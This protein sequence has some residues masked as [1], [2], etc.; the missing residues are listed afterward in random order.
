MMDDAARVVG[1]VAAVPAGGLL[2]VIQSMASTSQA[3]LDLEVETL[4]DSQHRQALLNRLRRAAADPGVTALIV[5]FSSPPG[6]WAACA[7]LRVALQRLRRAGKPVYAVLEQPG[8]AL[9]WMASVADRV[10]L[11]PTGEVLLVGIAAELTFFG[12]LLARIGVEPD[13]EAAGTYKSFG[14]PYT[15][16]FASPANQEAIGALIADL[17]DQ[18]VTGLAEARNLTVETVRALLDRAPLS[19]QDALDARLVDALAYNDEVETWIEE[20]HGKRTKK[21]DFLAWA[22]R[23]AA[24][25]ATERWGDVAE[26]IAVVHLDGAIVV[27]D[28]SPATLIRARRVVPLLAKLREDDDVKAVVLHVNSGGGGALASDLIWREVDLLQ[29]KKPVIA[30]FEDV[31]ASG[32]FYLAAPAAEILARPTT[33]TGSIGVFGGKLVVGE[34]MRKIGVHAHSIAGAPN[35]A[36]FS[37]ARHFTPDQRT[38]FKASLQRFYDGFVGRVAAGRHRPVEEIE[39]HC[40][41]RVWTGRAARDLGLIDRHGDL[42]D[43]IDRARTLANLAPAAFRRR[44]YSVQKRSFVQRLVQN[45]MK[46]VVPAA[47][48]MAVP[49]LTMLEAMVGGPLPPGFA[50]LLTHPEQPLAMLP[51]SLKAR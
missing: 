19:A 10:F 50:L 12:D 48:Q 31:A 3:V 30:C 20:H 40:R 15:R 26:A 29:K 43:A 47:S 39:P 22:R 49:W 33:L 13:F 5:R 17:Q 51:F 25:E 24:I 35:A 2:R 34:G 46:H 21:V 9:L 4:E 41:G 44:D 37:P 28:D 45:A 14:E 32:G 6:S 18:L 16:A 7:D 1:S 42:S 23:D 38:R 11:V 27:D 8:N 36:L